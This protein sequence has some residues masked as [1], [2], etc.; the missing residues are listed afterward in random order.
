MPPTTLLLDRPHQRHGRGAVSAAR[1]E[2][3]QIELRT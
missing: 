1:V 3:D 2:V